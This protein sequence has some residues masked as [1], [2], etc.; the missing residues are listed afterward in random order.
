MTGTLAAW[1]AAVTLAVTG[2]ITGLYY[3]YS[4][5]VMPGL[6]AIGGGSAIRAMNSINVKI[7]NPLFFVTFFGPVVTATLT[8][9]LLLV[10]GHRPAAVLFLL[11]AAVYLFGA[12]LLTVAVNVPLNDLLAAT[13]VPADPAEAAR[14]WA[15]YSSRW[16]GW[17]T[18]RAA[19]SLV[20]LLLIG[21]GIY[22]W[23][24]QR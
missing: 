21:L 12:F 22:Q 15:D 11:A 2:A 18:V 23:H 9:V 20:S 24:R 10:L 5:S 8:G 17:N 4:V 13:A 6:N 3:A 7:Q 14:V 19:A 16:T 1:S